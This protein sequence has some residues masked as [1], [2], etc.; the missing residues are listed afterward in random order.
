MSERFY[1]FSNR[2]ILKFVC[3]MLTPGI[4][5]CSYAPLGEQRLQTNNRKKERDPNQI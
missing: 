2:M 4:S 3:T 1:L 5:L